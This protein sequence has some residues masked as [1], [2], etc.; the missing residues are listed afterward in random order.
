MNRNGK[1]NQTNDEELEKKPKKMKYTI[2]ALLLSLSPVAY[3]RCPNSQPCG[4]SCISLTKTCHV[5]TPVE[6]VTIAPPAP[7]PV[8]PTA[9]IYPDSESQFTI[10]GVDRDHNAISIWR[11]GDKRVYTC[12]TFSPIFANVNPGDVITSDGSTGSLEMWKFIVDTNK[13]DAPP[14]ND[15]L[16]LFNCDI[17]S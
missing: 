14:Y 12:N 6:P 11:P 5:T 7:P 3:G 2:F 1:L 17:G 8:L 16:N 13:M 4:A 9:P 15:A 10:V